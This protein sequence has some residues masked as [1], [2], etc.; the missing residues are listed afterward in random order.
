MEAEPPPA[1]EQDVTGHGIDST[2]AFAEATV[3]A[4]VPVGFVMLPSLVAAPL[5]VRQLAKEQNLTGG[6]LQD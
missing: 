5:Y 6:W 2:D 4:A 3:I 1:T